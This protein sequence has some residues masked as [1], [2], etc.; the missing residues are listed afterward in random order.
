[1][2]VAS[3]CSVCGAY[4]GYTG[5]RR[6][7][8]KSPHPPINCTHSGT[9]SAT[10][11]HATWLGVQQTM[12]ARVV[13]P[14]FTLPRLLGDRTAPPGRAGKAEGRAGDRKCVPRPIREA[15]GGYRGNRGAIEVNSP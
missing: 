8:V 12:R 6:L 14:P 2:C 5:A 3:P 4:I 1:M 9:H 11:P 10:M 13:R 15:I 7:H